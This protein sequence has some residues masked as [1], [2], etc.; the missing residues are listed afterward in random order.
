MSLV[1][2]PELSE[3]EKLYRGVLEQ[4]WDYQNDRPSSALFKDSNGVSVD[5][6]NGRR[7]EDCV[8][9]LN[10]RRSFPR[11]A[12][13]SVRD[14][15][16]VGAI[17]IYAPVANNPYHCEIYDDSEKNKIGAKKAKLLRDLIEKVYVPD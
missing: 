17:S 14:V 1:L 15:T 8:K 2:S 11:V 10:S 16:H 9:D 13:I 5:R 3:D 6:C 4:F 12:S 7:P